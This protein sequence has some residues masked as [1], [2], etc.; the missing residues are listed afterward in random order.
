MKITISA[1]SNLERSGSLKFFSGLAHVMHLS[2]PLFSA[3][4]LSSIFNTPSSVGCILFGGR[5]L[6]RKIILYLLIFD[7]NPYTVLFVL[8]GVEMEGGICAFSARD[9]GWMDG[10]CI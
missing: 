7:S 2:F 6:P 1:S 8:W 4:A 5:A 10:W 3:S 9:D